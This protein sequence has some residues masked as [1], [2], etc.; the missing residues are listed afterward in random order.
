MLK[1]FLKTFSIKK[2]V[3]SYFVSLHNHFKK[4]FIRPVKELIGLDIAKSTKSL[5]I[6][7]FKSTKC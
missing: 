4:K 5:L 2:Y 3:L 7:S 6:K 1:I